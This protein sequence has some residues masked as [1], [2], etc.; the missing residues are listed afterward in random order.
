ME[1]YLQLYVPSEVGKGNASSQEQIDSV[2]W[3]LFFIFLK[4]QTFLN[5]FLLQPKQDS[6]DSLSHKE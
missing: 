1:L 5:C 6:S 4:C 3:F 2:F